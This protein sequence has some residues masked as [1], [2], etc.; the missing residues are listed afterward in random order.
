MKTSISHIL[1]AATVTAGLVLAAASAQASNNGTWV[2][3]G[4]DS[5]F[6]IEGS[7][8]SFS[9]SPASMVAYYNDNLTPQSD[10]EI[11]NYLNAQFGLSG[12][13]AVGAAVSGCDNP[14]SNCSNAT[15]GVSG[16]ANTFNSSV[17]YDYL[18]IHFG[19]G[20]LF[21]HWTT[22]LGPNDTFMISGLP[23]GLSNY[24]AFMTAVPEPG[25]YA[26]LLAGL[27]I[28]GFAARRRDKQ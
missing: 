11:M 21:F 24:R 25:T 28:L 10:T 20:E 1:K 14:T 9:P 5:P 4:P 3:V 2:A 16:G 7:S 27:G 18:A 12:S 23:H 19:Q 22:P 6:V 8:V 13:S 15:G 17:P 26:M